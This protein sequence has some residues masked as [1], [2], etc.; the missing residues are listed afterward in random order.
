VRDIRHTGQQ[1]LKFLPRWTHPFLCWKIY[2]SW[3]PEVLSLKE[4]PPSPSPALAAQVSRVLC[5][6][7]S[8]TQSCSSVCQKLPK[9]AV[10]C[11]NAG[12]CSSKKNLVL[13]NGHQNAC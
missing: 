2:L 5:P 3:C 9:C 13:L 7:S 8:T 12:T 11:K 1:K 6:W 4:H 10:H